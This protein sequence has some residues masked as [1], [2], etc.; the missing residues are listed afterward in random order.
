MIAKATLQDVPAVAA[1]AAL[2]WPQ[3][4]AEE[5]APDFEQAVSRSDN[6]V[7]LCCAEGILVGFAHCSLRHDYVEGTDSSPVGYLEGIFVREQYRRCGFAKALLVACEAWA[8]D[9]GCAE[10]ASD[11]ELDN[12]TSLFFHKKLGFTEANRIV[13]FQKML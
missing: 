9:M 3:H 11:C 10:F 5:L 12:E 2:L 8:K 1:L 6:A 7:F 4:T 13:C